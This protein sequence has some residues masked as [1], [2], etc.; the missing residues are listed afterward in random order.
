MRR[1]SSTSSD[2][3]SC[4]F[5]FS[6]PASFPFQ[7]SAAVFIVTAQHLR[8]EFG[9]FWLFGRSSVSPNCGKP[10]PGA[11]ASCSTGALTCECEKGRRTLGGEDRTASRRA[12]VSSLALS[13]TLAQIPTRLAPIWGFR[14][15]KFPKTSPSL[16]LSSH[17]P[18]APSNGGQRAG[19]FQT[20]IA[21]FEHS[22]LSTLQQTAVLFNRSRAGP[23]IELRGFVHS[24]VGLS[25]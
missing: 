24:Q 14:R 5:L 21:L 20:P 7:Q 25:V 11:L 23:L 9:D 13:G 4:L 10:V 8:P 3:P 12:P 22:T 2:D 16:S 18:P 19:R 17:R 6:P 15:R 1:C